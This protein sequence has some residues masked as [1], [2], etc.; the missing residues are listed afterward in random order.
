MATLAH[1]VHF[2]RIPP[3]LRGLDRWIGWREKPVLERDGTPKLNEDGTPK[4]TKVPMQVPDAQGVVCEAKSNDPATWS[5]FQAVQAAYEAGVFTGVGF[6]FNGDGIIGVDL[7]HCVEHA[8]VQESLFFDDPEPAAGPLTLAPWAEEIVDMLP[9]TYWELSP[10]GTGLH[11]I[12]AGGALPPKGRKKGP[13]EVYETV[14]FFTVTGEV[15]PPGTAGA[16]VAELPAE[17]LALHRHVF[18]DVA[19]AADPARVA[20][21]KARNA[22]RWAGVTAGA[23]PAPRGY[24]SGTVEPVHVISKE[25]ARAIYEGRWQQYYGTDQ[26]R[27]D[28]AFCIFAVWKGLSA[29]AIQARMHAPDCQL[30]RPK[31]DEVHHADGRTYGEGTIDHA[32]AVVAAGQYVI[33]PDPIRDAAGQALPTPPDGLSPTREAPDGEAVVYE[34]ALIQATLSPDDV[35]AYYDDWADDPEGFRPFT[36]AELAVQLAARGHTLPIRTE[37]LF[38]PAGGGDDGDDGG[39]D[40]GD[41]VAGDAVSAPPPPNGHVSRQVQRAE[42]R[43][44]AAAVAGGDAGGNGRGNGRRPAPAGR[45]EGRG[46]GS[47]DGSS[48][49]GPVIY[50][51]DGE[52]LNGHG[53]I[54]AAGLTGGPGTD[55]EHGITPT[56]LPAAQMSCKEDALG[57]AE[58]FALRHRHHARFVYTSAR[59][60]ASGQWATYDARHWE[61]DTSH[62]HEKM[63]LETFESIADEVPLLPTVAQQTSRANHHA[64]SRDGAAFER[65]LR[66]AAN[67]CTLYGGMQAFDAYP[68]LLNVLNGIIDLTTGVLHPHEPALYQMHM[69]PVVYDPNLDTAEW[70]GWVLDWVNGNQEYA[71]HLQRALGIA[72]TGD[73]SPEVFW[74]LVGGPLTAK[75]TWVEATSHALGSYHLSANF[76]TFLRKR[77]PQSGPNNDIAA[78]MGKRYIT[79]VEVDEG[80]ELAQ[81]LLKKLTGGDTITARFLYEELFEYR[82]QGKLWLVANEKPRLHNALDEAFWRRPIILPFEGMGFLRDPRVKAR[83]EADP[84]V[85]AQVIVWAVRG[86]LKW[87]AEGKRLEKPQVALERAEQYRRENDTF[88]EFLGAVCVVAKELGPDKKPVGWSPENT[89][90]MRVRA[91]ALYEAYVAYRKDMG[92]GPHEMLS[93]TRFGLEMSKRFAKVHDRDGWWYVGVGL[94][95]V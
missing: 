20:A 81:G 90:G 17:V 70:E 85:W 2:D 60:G 50:G 3:R 15:W 16:D 11:G 54:S 49:G 64:K 10:S 76:E 78:M 79:S 61:R 29:E 38:G 80:T 86:V 59:S 93:S 65:T 1:T 75:S 69:A 35:Q 41:D 73:V 62:E 32:F 8:P 28:D 88:G 56:Y 18:G 12:V 36:E 58:R 47:G 19:A 24:H 84:A 53:G 45:G 72:L 68:Y 31:W 9:G 71:E 82:F 6:V 44:A 13:V 55:T 46:D 22:G 48:D 21:L 92:A 7:D 63:L 74:F 66:L 25:K 57:N 67:F 87:F 26:S 14:R 30:Y 42:A 23:L 95:L 83:C 94:R 40:E 4:R 89:E 34:A 27:A 43:K 52:R 39:G 51:P 77:W 91:G 37:D 33:E 5:S